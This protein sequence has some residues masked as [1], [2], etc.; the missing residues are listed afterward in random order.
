MW[1]RDRSN[2]KLVYDVVD[3]HGVGNAVAQIKGVVLRAPERIVVKV[4]AIGV[5]SEDSSAGCGSLKEHVVHEGGR[6]REQ[7]LRF[8][9]GQI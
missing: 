5:V 8:L 2:R 7:I 9:S 3:H 1:C 4:Q 6:H